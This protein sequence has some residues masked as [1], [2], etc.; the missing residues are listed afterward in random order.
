MCP[1]QGCAKRPPTKEPLVSLGLECQ[2]AAGVR[3]R[4][5]PVPSSPRAWPRPYC[6]PGI[7]G[8]LVLAPGPGVFSP[9]CPCHLGTSL[10]RL[11]QKDAQMRP[12]GPQLPGQQAPCS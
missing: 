5:A 1:V 9:A 7:A 3:G 4:A 2:P 12:V 8:A 10:L 11:A 6:L